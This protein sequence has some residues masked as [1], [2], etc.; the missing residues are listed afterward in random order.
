MGPN[1]TVSTRYYDDDNQISFITGLSSGYITS[2]T[3]ANALG[4]GTISGDPNR[5][6]DNFV[7]RTSRYADDIVNLRLNE[8]PQI[9]E[10]DININIFGGIE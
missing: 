7:F 6:I 8:L 2:A 3:D 1:A 4:R 10:S 5:K 9:E